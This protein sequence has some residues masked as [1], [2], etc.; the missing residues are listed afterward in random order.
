[1]HKF[2]TDASFLCR[3]N[4]LLTPLDLLGYQASLLCSFPRLSGVCSPKFPDRFRSFVLKCVLSHSSSSSRNAGSL[5]GYKTRQFHPRFI[6]PPSPSNI[7]SSLN[8]SNF[9]DI[10]NGKQ[11][12]RQT[13]HCSIENEVSLLVHPLGG[14]HHC[15]RPAGFRD[16]EMSHS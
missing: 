15:R 11:T 10:L 2:K 6:N 13:L 8:P 16:K 3:Y 14:Y 12:E 5:V 9:L 7:V 4:F 1:M